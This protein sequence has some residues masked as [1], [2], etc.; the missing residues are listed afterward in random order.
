RR[1][2]PSGG[3][4][5]ALTVAAPMNTL[6]SL[7]IPI[8]NEEP[9]LPEMYRRLSAALD[10]SPADLAY[11]ILFVDDGSTDASIE[12][13]LEL[14]RRDPRVKLIALSRN[15][16]NPMAICAGVDHADGGAVI[17]I[18]GDLQDPPELI[19]TLISRWREGAEVVYAVRSRRQ[20]GLIRR[21]AT[22]AFYRLLRSVAAQSM[23]LDSGSF[24]LMDR[25]VVDVLTAM[26][27]RSRYVVGL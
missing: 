22:A 16:G 7:V 12:A 10:R 4:S 5:G 27:E 15:F 23:P 3:R 6:V 9:N 8:K 20:E 13:V 17:L 2:V 24:S 11:E 1:R 25:Q 21:A 14:R 19:P 18:D 26:P